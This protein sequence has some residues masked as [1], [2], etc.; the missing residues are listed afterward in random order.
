MYKYGLLVA[1]VLVLA[2]CGNKKKGGNENNPGSPSSMQYGNNAGNAG[3]G[4]PGSGA[5][6]NYDQTGIHEVKDFYNCAVTLSER[7]SSGKKVAELVASKSPSLDSTERV[8]ELTVSNVAIMFYDGLRQGRNK[9][10][11]IHSTVVF[12]DGQRAEKSYAAPALDL[13]LT[14]MRVVNSIVEK[15]KSGD[16]DGLAP[17]LNEKTGIMEYDKPKFIA[18]VKR[19]DPGLG[20]VKEFIPYG[21]MFIKSD[22]K[23]DIL[24]ISGMLMRDR[25]NNEFSVDIDPASTKEEALFFNY[26]F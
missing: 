1:A 22:T 15:L 10:D 12:G 19:A 6:A 5:N 25:Q 18:Q 14:K 4:V 17:L 9:Y 24:H 21:F 23:R 13:V 20:K 7:T 8:A 16:Y 3:P 2:S 11:V 26:K